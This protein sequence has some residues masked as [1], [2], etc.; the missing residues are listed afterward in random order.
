MK[1]KLF[2]FLLLATLQ[3]PAYADSNIDIE[4]LRE[5][6][7][8]CQ[9]LLVEGT[10]KKAKKCF[11]DLPDISPIEGVRAEPEEPPQVE[12]HASPPSKTRLQKCRDLAKSYASDDEVLKCF[13]GLVWETRTQREKCEKTCVTGKPAPASPFTSWPD[14]EL[15]LR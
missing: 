13:K 14:W 2:G 12:I 1:R 15:P 11:D 3:V 8:K 10:F 4:A 6:H 9:K 5:A 7:Q